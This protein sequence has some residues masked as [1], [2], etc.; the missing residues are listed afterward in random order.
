MALFGLLGNDRQMAATT[1]NGQESATAK[2]TRKR[3]QGH[4]RDVVKVARQGQAW[5]D[6]QRARQDRGARR[7]KRR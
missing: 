7:G 4:R 2:G 6:D 3:R 5:E 1:Y